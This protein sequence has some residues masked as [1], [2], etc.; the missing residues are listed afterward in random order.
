MMALPRFKLIS[1]GLCPYVQRA[2]IMLLEKDVPHEVEYIDLDRPPPWFYDISPLGKVP[3]LLVDGEPLF[4]SMAI[5]EYLDEITPGS[6]HPADPFARARNR[7][8]IEF[9]NGILDLTYR[10]YNEKDETG[11]KRHIAHL[12]DRFEIL[13]EELGPGPFF[14]GEAFSIIDAVYAPIFLYHAAVRQYE[15]FGFFQ[16]TLLI[17][18]WTDA[19][20]TRPSV[21]QGVPESYDADLDAYLRRR[22]SLLGERVREVSGK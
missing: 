21:R 6:M 12:Q 16:E 14:N 10:F 18:A 8:W 20:L 5:C 9:G 13:E 17:N 11:F 3:V 2:R 19:L 1:F 22:D 15:D 7:A 4:E